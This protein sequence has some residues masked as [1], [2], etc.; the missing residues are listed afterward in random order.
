MALLGEIGE[1]NLQNEPNPS[2]SSIYAAVL[3]SGYG[4]QRRKSMSAQM[5]ASGWVTG[6]GLLTVSFVGR[7]TSATFGRVASCKKRTG[8][9]SYHCDYSITNECLLARQL[10]RGVKPTAYGRRELFSS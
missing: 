4:P 6:L 2:R 5:S 3:E 9:A 8:A 10:I 1:V 7:D